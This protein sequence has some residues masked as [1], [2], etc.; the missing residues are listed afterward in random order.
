MRDPV[1]VAKHKNLSTVCDIVEISSKT[2]GDKYETNR[3][4]RLGEKSEHSV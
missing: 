1:S 4:F 2:L 3:V